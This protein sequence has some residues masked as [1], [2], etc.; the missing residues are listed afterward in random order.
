MATIANNSSFCE[1][2]YSLM[3]ADVFVYHNIIDLLVTPVV[4]K[5][6]RFPEI[7]SELNGYSVLAASAKVVFILV[8]YYT[9]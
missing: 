2:Y 9:N 5:M 8:Q 6:R 4:V 7:E 1:G 3:C